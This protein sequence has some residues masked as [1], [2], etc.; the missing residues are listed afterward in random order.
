CKVPSCKKGC[1]ISN[2]IPE[3]IGELAKGNFGNAMS[4]I[5]ERS[6]LPAVCGRVCGHERQCEGNCVLGKKGQHIN[7]G[8][9]ERFVAD[10]DSEA[11]LTHEAIPVKNRGKVAVIGSGPAGLTIAGDLSRQGFAVEIFEME[12]EPGGVLMYGIP[13]YRLPKEVVRREIKKIEN[14]GVVFHLNTTIGENYTIDDLFAQGFDA[15]FM[16]TGT[17]VPNRLD[18]PGINHP[19]V[20]Q[21][22]RFLRRVSLFE[23]GWMSRDE[24]IVGNGDIVFVIGCG[25]TAIDAARTALRMGSKEVNVIY[26][27]TVDN[28]NALR[29]EYEDA[30]KEGVNFFWNTNL[31]SIQAEDSQRIKTVTLNID[32]KETVL[33]A[34]HVVMAIGSAPA[35]RIVSSTDGIDVDDKGYVLTRENP[36]GMSSRKGVFAGGDVTNRPAT[37]VHAMRDAK[38]VAEGIAR[39]VDAVKLMESINNE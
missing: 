38:L 21:A 5:N 31:V 14:L 29:A 13:E 7:I 24:V 10:F 26:H 39:Y 27:R 8:K 17:G 33:P 6:N 34:D 3:W 23:S 19:A 16:G 12:P 35:S 1:P 30:V 32:G 37:V 15:I 28:M 20:R 2:D 9:L 4:I 11:D 36:Y 22:I 18:I 25:N